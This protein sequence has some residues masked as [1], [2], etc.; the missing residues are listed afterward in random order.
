MQYSRK[1]ES[2]R[3]RAPRRALGALLIC[4]ALVCVAAP[5]ARAASGALWIVD[6]DND[7]VDEYLPSQ[8]KSS[9]TPTPLTISIGAAPYGACFDKSKNLWV[10]DDD[11]EILGFTASELKKLPTAPSAAVTI[12]SSSFSGIEGCTF[13]KHGNLWLMDRGNDSLDEISAAQLKAG[14]GPI[15]PA[16]IITDS[17]QMSS[18]APGFVT[19]DKSG[20]LWTD[21]REV[22]ELF[23][24]SAS[25]LTTTGDKTAAVV[26]GGGGSLND[27]GQIGFDGHGNLWVGSYSDDTVVEFPKGQLSTSNNDAPAVTISSSSLDGPWGLAFHGS[28]LWVMDYADV[29]A[30]EFTPGQIKATGSPAPKVLLT[31]AAA[32]YSWGITF[33]PAFGKLP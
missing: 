3:A 6:E 15:T 25:Q 20:N 32:K 5:A 14:S 33:G 10:T 21:G 26:L 17:T 4:S 28:D 24:F 27:P 19:F 30:Q 22:D 1:S 23:E 13:D 7:R 12:T 11:E 8:L 31:G 29:N 2:V 9:H 16:V 18:A